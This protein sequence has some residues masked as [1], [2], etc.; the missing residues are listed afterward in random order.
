MKAPIAP[1]EEKPVAWVPGLSGDKLKFRFVYKDVKVTMSRRQEGRSW[2]IKPKIQGKQ[3]WISLEVTASTRSGI[4]LAV[5]RVKH[6]LDEPWAWP[7]DK[8]RPVQAPAPKPMSTVG[9]LIAVYEAKASALAF[10]NRVN[11]DTVDKNTASLCR[12]IRW[13]KG[14]DGKPNDEIEV[15]DLRLSILTKDLVDNFLSNYMAAVETLNHRDRNELAVDRRA[16]GA[17]H[18]LRQIREG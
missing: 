16:N 17:A 10:R 4:E 3:N 12:V 11:P 14:K 5:K 13:A 9:E 15:K 7:T 18:V 1:S 6:K 8:P 2:E